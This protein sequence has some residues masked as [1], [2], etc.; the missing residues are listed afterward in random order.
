MMGNDFQDLGQCVPK[1]H[2]D[3][4]LLLHHGMR[5]LDVFLADQSGD[6]LVSVVI[7]LGTSKLCWP[8]RTPRTEINL[9]N[10]RAW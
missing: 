6:N 10:L 7:Q 2:G 9:M 8:Y 3:S 5:L 4:H 1:H